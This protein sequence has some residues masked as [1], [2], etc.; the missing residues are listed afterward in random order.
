MQACFPRATARAI[1]PPSTIFVVFQSVRKLFVHTGAKRLRSDSPRQPKYGTANKELVL[2][3]DI[4]VSRVMKA[5]H[6]RRVAC[7]LANFVR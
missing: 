7:D 4:Y 3:A 5:T 6:K 2:C 1:T